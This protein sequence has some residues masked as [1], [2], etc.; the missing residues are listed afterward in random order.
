MWNTNKG[1]TVVCIKASV[2]TLA[3]QFVGAIY[4]TEMY[5]ICPSVV[6]MLC[7]SDGNY[8]TIPTITFD[9]SGNQILDWGNGE[10]W[11]ITGIFTFYL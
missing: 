8:M 6:S 5:Q 4:A 7:Q 2:E 11:T 1:S 9:P 10:L 3:C